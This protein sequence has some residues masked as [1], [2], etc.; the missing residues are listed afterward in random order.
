ME[1]NLTQSFEWWLERAQAGNAVAQ[2]KVGDMYLHGEGVEVD[3]DQA[4]EWYIKA[5]DQGEDVFYNL[6]VADLFRGVDKDIRPTK[7]RN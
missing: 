4:F 5:A 3:Y 7:A 2:H 1:K 6:A